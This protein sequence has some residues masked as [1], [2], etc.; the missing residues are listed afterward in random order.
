MNYQRGMIASD[1]TV[2][3]SEGWTIQDP[4]SGLL[5]YLD[6]TGQ[7]VG[8]DMPQAAYASELGTLGEGQAVATDEYGNA[9][10]TRDGQ[11]IVAPAQAT[12]MYDEAYPSFT[13]TVMPEPATAPAPQMVAPQE[14]AIPPQQMY[15][16]PTMPSMSS[17]GGDGTSSGQRPSYANGVQNPLWSG[18]PLTPGGKW[19]DGSGGT[20]QHQVYVPGGPAAG[21]Y[22]TRAALPASSGGNSYG[23]S[24]GGGSGGGGGGSALYQAWRDKLTAKLYPGSGSGYSGSS[25]GGTS[26]G[27]PPE[28]KMHGQWARKVDPSQASALSYRPSMLIPKV[29]PG[30][31]STSPLYQEMAAEPASQLGT[32]LSGTKRVKQPV[33]PSSHYSQSAGGYVSSKG[34]SGNVGSTTVNS[35]GNFYDRAINK[36]SYPTFGE[37]IHNLDTAGKRSLIGTQLGGT[38]PLGYAAQNASNLYSAAFSTL[39]SDTAAAYGA[40]VEGLIDKYGSK[41]LKKPVGKAPAMNKWV[42]KRTSF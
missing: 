34:K 42:G 33:Y 39:P 6:E 23:G 38:V 40:E 32:I 10:M 31:S 19:N 41:F 7:A 9:L 12:G 22:S 21:P 2:L 36:E 4:Q 18:Q 24:A 37:L 25:G 5:T 8:H 16:T 26:S 13:P 3:S 30:L 17:F 14:P 27:Y 35:L 15:T 11:Y 1:G 29:A 28:E 20:G